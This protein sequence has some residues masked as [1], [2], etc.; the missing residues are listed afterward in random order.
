MTI[1]RRG[2]LTAAV[3]AAAAVPLIGAGPAAATK[4][5]SPGSYPGSG[6]FTSLKV[7]GISCA[8]GRDVEKGHYRC[9]TKHGVQGKCRSFNG[10]SCSERRP[11]SGR[12]KVEYN[13]KVTCKKSNRTVVYTYQQNI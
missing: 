13:A 2:L 7:T 3:A 1:A 6:Y 4:N 10:Y 8:G 5:C 9:R 11:A 12:N